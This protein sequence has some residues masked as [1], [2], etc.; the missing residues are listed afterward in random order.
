MI[1]GWIW[2]NNE[3]TSMLIF[4]IGITLSYPIFAF[5]YGLAGGWDDPTLAELE[6]AVELTSFMKPM[7]W[8]FWK[9]T[10]TGAKLS[11]IHNRFPIKVRIGAMEEAQKLQNKRVPI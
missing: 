1:T 2:R 9:S 10:A 7:A 8:L 4:F 3:I 6:Q 11:P 5:F